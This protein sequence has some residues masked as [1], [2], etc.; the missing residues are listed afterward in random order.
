MPK[1]AVSGATFA[2]HYLGER[3]RYLVLTRPW[4][5]V[6]SFARLP[7]YG[8]ETYS[9]KCHLPGMSRP[10]KSC[11]PTA[12]PAAAGRIIELMM[13]YNRRAAD[14]NRPGQTHHAAPN[15]APFSRR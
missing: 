14:A 5:A 13:A 1:R 9:S 7:I 12:A 8:L 2:K 11:L 4:T 3:Y 10:R 15:G 6:A